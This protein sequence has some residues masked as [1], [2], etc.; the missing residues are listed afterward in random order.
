[1]MTTTAIFVLGLALSMLQASIEGISL[2]KSHLGM[3]LCLAKKNLAPV[4][5]RVHPKE[6]KRGKKVGSW[7]EA[8]KSKHYRAWN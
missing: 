5:C 8:Q 7:L 6:G 1:M 2:E 4:L 3:E